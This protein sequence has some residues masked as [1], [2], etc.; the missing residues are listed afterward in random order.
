[1]QAPNAYT[2]PS[3]RVGGGGAQFPSGCGAE[4]KVV[5]VCSSGSTMGVLATDVN[6]RRNRKS[7]IMER[8]VSE[9]K[10][11]LILL[12]INL[13]IFQLLKRRDCLTLTR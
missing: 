6:Q 3:R 1:M 5:P 11:K 7:V 12:F 8:T 10:V 4:V 13:F 2:R 9:G